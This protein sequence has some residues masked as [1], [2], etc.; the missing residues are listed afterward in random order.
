MRD[1]VKKRCLGVYFVIL[2]THSYS[3]YARMVLSGLL[4][5]TIVA[6]L[7]AADFQFS[8]HQYLLLSSIHRSDED[9]W[10]GG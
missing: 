3:W 2:R 10:T 4:L 7:Q 9:P 8:L 1:K 5:N 6:V